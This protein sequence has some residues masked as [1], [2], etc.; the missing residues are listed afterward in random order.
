MHAAGV[1]QVSRNGARQHACGAP[2]DA[3]WGGRGPRGLTAERSCLDSRS[4]T[5]D[6]DTAAGRWRG[7]QRCGGPLIADL[8]VLNTRSRTSTTVPTSIS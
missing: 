6:R 4:G 8:L 5:E 2:E 3:A 1:L 7:R